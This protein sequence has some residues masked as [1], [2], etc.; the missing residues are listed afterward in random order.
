MVFAGFLAESLSQRII[1]C[2][3]KALLTCNAVHGG[4]KVINLKE[5]ADAA[6]VQSSE[7][8]VSIGM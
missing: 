2:K 5:I 8:G 4:L 3:P 7:N 6:L 1:D